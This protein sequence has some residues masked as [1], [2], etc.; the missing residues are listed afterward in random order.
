MKYNNVPHKIKKW[1][2]QPIMKALGL[3]VYLQTRRA[4]LYADD[5]CQINKSLST[6]GQY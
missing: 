2:K 1:K 4:L 3:I 5:R 6:E